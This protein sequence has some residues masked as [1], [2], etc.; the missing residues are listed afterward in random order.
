MS[1]TKIT[2]PFLEHDHELAYR[3]SENKAKEWIEKQGWLVDV[4]MSPAMP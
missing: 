1:A 2:V 3:W 4:I